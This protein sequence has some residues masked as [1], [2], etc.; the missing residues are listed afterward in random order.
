MNPP[1]AQIIE[2]A[3]TVWGL[4]LQPA[5]CPACRRTYLTEAGRLGQPCPACARGRL[6]AQPAF[7]RPEL[8]ELALPFARKPADLRPA[9]EGFVQPVWLR[10]PDLAAERLLQRAVPVFWPMWLVDAQVAGAWQ[11]EL[12]FDYQVK[13]SQEAFRDG[14]WRTTEV[15]ETR[16]HWEPRCGEIG[17]RYHNVPAPALGD[18]A[19]LTTLIGDYP[20]AEARAYSAEMVRG[21]TLRVPDLPPESAWPLA[22]AA[23]DRL[24][25]EDCQRAAGA[26]HVREIQLRVDYA[27]PNWTQLLL[28]LYATYYLD[29]DGQPQPVLING[30]TGRVGGRRLASVRRGQ[31]IALWMAAGALGLFLLGVLILLAGALFPPLLMLGGVLAVAALALGAGALAPAL[32]P[33]QW[34]SRQTS[35][36]SGA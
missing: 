4:D 35:S 6:E 13:S 32:W 28:P 5:G 33:R 11:A 23:L 9:L 24:A 3:Q 12:G 16:A 18:Q 2:E 7:M 27:A 34:N 30:R 21:A 36:T 8:P 17:R 19:A 10:P 15:L 14:Q 25:G 26:Q 20:L 29:D 22:Q 31:Q 1:N